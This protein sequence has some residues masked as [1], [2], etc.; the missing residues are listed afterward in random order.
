MIHSYYSEYDNVLLRPLAKQDIEK[1]R[2]W[3]NNT[4]ETKYL[5]NIGYIDES[6][7][8]KWYESYLNREDEVVFAIVETSLLNRCVGSLSL[9]DIKNGIAE[10]GKIQIGD[11]NAHHMG[12]GHKS[13][14]MAMKIGFELIGLNRIIASVHRDNVAAR[15]NDLKIGFEITGEHASTVGGIE[16]ELSIKI[17]KLKASNEYYEDITIRKDYKEN[18]E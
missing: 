18:C 5:R 15:T 3:R 16:D 14:V 6:M 8:K 2:V 10:I 7:Q 4:E 12:I 9:Y 13:L 17:D 11:P 1:L